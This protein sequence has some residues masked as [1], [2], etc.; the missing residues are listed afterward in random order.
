MKRAAADAS[1]P[2]SRSR[3]NSNLSKLNANRKRAD[4]GLAGES[5]CPPNVNYQPLPVEAQAQL[6]QTLIARPRRRKRRRRS[7]VARRVHRRGRVEPDDVQPVADR[8][9]T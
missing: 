4:A 7:D 6:Q 2:V 3:P 5:A 9:S 1:S 8:K